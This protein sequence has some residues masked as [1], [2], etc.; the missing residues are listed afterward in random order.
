MEYFLV[1][2]GFLVQKG[3]EIWY[4]IPIY[5]ILYF[6]SFHGTLNLLKIDNLFQ[7]VQNIE[8]GQNERL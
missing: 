2:V 1:G 8:L 6:F 3:W 4:S 7:R 5:I